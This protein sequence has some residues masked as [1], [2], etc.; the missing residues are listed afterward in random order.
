MSLRRFP[1]RRLAQLGLLLAGLLLAAAG[2]RD[3]APPGERFTPSESTA[4]AALETALR[5]WQ[6]GGPVDSL[7]F[8]GGRAHLADGQQ[9]AGRRLQ[10][11]DILGEGSAHSGRRYLV[12]IQ[13][14][15]PDPPQKVNYVVIGI[16]PVW[17]IRQQD[18]EMLLHWDHPMDGQPSAAKAAAPPTSPDEP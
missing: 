3:S 11:F 4:R 6:V 7:A 1:E 10:R 9:A 17:V 16:D 18:L 2:C 14:D 5:A 12:Q 15:G 8:D 13:L